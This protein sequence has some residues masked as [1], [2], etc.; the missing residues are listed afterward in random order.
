MR[1]D[2]GCA[3]ATAGPRAITRCTAVLLGTAVAVFRAGRLVRRC[4][5]ARCEP[6]AIGT[7]PAAGSEPGR[8]EADCKTV[9]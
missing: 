8:E 6:E 4:V 2:P 9:R 7:D 3:L 5:A 1:T